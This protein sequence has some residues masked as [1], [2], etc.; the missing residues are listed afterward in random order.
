[1]GTELWL[2]GLDRN[3]LLNVGRV[4]VAVWTV[5]VPNPLCYVGTDLSCVSERAGGLDVYSR[6]MDAIA[7]YQEQ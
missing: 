6:W 7:A 5:T 4:Y 3:S 2:P 1:M